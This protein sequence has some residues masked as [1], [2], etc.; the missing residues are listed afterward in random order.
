MQFVS[1]FIRRKFDNLKKLT[2]TDFISVSYITR[3]KLICNNNDNNNREALRM[4]HISLEESFLFE[5]KLTSGDF[6]IR[7]LLISLYDSYT[8]MIVTSLKKLLRISFG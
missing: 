1:Y 5:K 6:I 4:L 8:L 3:R 2:R 7:L